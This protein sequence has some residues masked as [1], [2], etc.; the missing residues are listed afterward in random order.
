MSQELIYRWIARVIEHLQR[1]L[2]L[3]GMSIKKGG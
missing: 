1:V 3:E 2:K